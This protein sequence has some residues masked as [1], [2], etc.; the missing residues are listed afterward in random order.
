MKYLRYLLET[1]LLEARK[2]ADHP[3]Q[4]KL[5]DMEPLDK[6]KSLSPEQLANHF[7]T[8]T[9]EDKVGINTSPAARRNPIGVYTYALS[10]IL[11]FSKMTDAEFAGNG[12]NL[13]ILQATKPILRINKYNNFDLDKSKLIKY[14]ETKQVDDKTINFVQQQNNV[15]GERFWNI[16]S[17][18]ARIITNDK[19]DNGQKSIKTLTE[20][21]VILRKV[22]NYHIINDQDGSI[23]GS[24]GI[25]GS[26]CVFLDVQS[27]K[28]V[29]K[30]KNTGVNSYG[31][32]KKSEKMRRFLSDKNVK[33]MEVELSSGEDITIYYNPM[34]VSTDKSNNQ[35]IF[36]HST[37]FT[38]DQVIDNRTSMMTKV[39]STNDI[40]L[41]IK[42]RTDGSR[43][44]YDTNMRQNMDNFDIPSHT[45]KQ[46]LQE[47]DRKQF[48]VLVT[49]IH[50]EI[51]TFFEPITHSYKLWFDRV[52][53]NEKG[54]YDEDDLSLAK[55]R[56]QTLTDNKN[57]KR[58]LGDIPYYIEGFD[59][60]LA[61]K[62]GDKF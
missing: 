24:D 16:I 14:L 3:A 39:E 28:I 4:K 56:M 26:Q 2:N 58:I 61:L 62:L 33:E 19:L 1:H 12:N 44:S 10:K 18:I 54:T 40:G 57:L 52:Q 9:T 34:K 43:L 35:E 47:L 50:D 55:E 60:A 27:F 41:V 30:I 21:N 6:Y 8:Y 11:Q 53:K 48:D 5:Y 29:E 45:I 32:Q 15:N 42:A 23:L 20:M 49:I 22:L 51:V 46:M 59:K 37:V 25:A 13:F 7:A 31:E 17:K 38:H 36:I